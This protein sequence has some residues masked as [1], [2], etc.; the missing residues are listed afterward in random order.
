MGCIR[1][2]WDDNDYDDV[3][4]RVLLDNFV[5]II[6]SQIALVNCLKPAARGGCSLPTEAA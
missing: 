1:I 3:D 2:A 6:R 5:S 4:G